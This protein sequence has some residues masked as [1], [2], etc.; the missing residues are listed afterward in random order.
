MTA[1]LYVQQL[2]PSDILCCAGDFL[3]YNKP[4]KEEAQAAEAL[5]A[6]Q[7]AKLMKICDAYTREEAVAAC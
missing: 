1:P 3:K 2:S 4:R 5:T 7:D 6:L